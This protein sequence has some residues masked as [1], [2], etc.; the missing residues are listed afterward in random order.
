MTK[1][2][3]YF[4]TRILIKSLPENGFKRI[5]GFVQVFTKKNFA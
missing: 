3:L 5:F 1:R 2:K 4:K